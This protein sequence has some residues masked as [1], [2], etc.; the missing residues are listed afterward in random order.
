MGNKTIY[1]QDEKLWQKAKKLAGKPGLSGV[2]ARALE[3]FVDRNDREKQGFRRYQFEVQYVHDDDEFVMTDYVAFEAKP[4]FEGV[5]CFQPP[6]GE[7][8]DVD[9]PFDR[10]QVTVYQT[11]KGTLILTARYGPSLNKPIFHYGSHQ[12]M[13]AL[14]KDSVVSNLTPDD[15][16]KLLADLSLQ[17]R[18]TLVIWID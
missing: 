6:E 2:I 18:E 4:L 14:A 16:A 1:V 12:S 9:P 8:I 10:A 7:D 5:L 3:E 11:T 15:R 13:A 17:L